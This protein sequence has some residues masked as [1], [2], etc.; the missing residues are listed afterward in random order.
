LIL[1]R[2]FRA[3]TASVVRRFQINAAL[4]TWPSFPVAAPVA[5]RKPVQGTSPAEETIDRIGR[6]VRETIRAVA[7][8]LRL[9]KK[10]GMPWYVGTDLVVLVGE[11]THH[12]G[13]EFWRG[14]TVPDPHHLLQ[15]TGKNLR[16]V[17]LRTLGD[18]TTPALVALLRAAVQLDRTEPPRP[19]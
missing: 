12:V 8:E 10:W 1:K 7:P 13:V 9:E 16:H 15:G 4:H 11:Y 6:A 5:P 2:I 18:A 17:T 3:S 14:T 19:R